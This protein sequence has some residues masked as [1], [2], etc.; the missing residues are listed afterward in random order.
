MK[1]VLILFPDTFLWLKDNTGLLY[2]AKSFEKDGF[3][4]T[5]ALKSLCSA[6]LFVD[7]L[8]TIEIEPENL[9]A[10]EVKFVDLVIRKKYG[11]ITEH[12]AKAYSLPPVLSIQ[13]DKKKWS[14]IFPEALTKTS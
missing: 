12:P 13:N 4:Y 1:Q 7:N 2:N 5:P 11:F 3:N 10:E 8:Y 6:L 14:S 9:T